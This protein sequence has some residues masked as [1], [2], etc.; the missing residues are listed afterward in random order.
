MKLSRAI[1]PEKSS[2]AL[3]DLILD[4]G[5][6]DEL[7]MAFPSFRWHDALSDAIASLILLRRAVADSR[8]GAEK[9]E[10]LLRPDASHYHRLGQKDSVLG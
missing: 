2:F 1:W 6:E 9:A 8:V 10:I 7:R 5:L 4:L 3:G